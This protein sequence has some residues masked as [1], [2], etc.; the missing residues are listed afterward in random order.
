MSY[1]DWDELLGR[2]VELES[3]TWV[4]IRRA[5]E[6]SG[7]SRSTLRA[8]YRRGEVPSRLADGPHG[9]ERHVP[10][11]AVLERAA[12]AR[13]RGSRDGDDLADKVAQQAEEIAALRQRIDDL[14]R[15]AR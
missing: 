10:L 14:E 12:A 11:E 4:T 6:A 1:V 7:A 8:W 15:R 9:P 2:A 3:A 5:V 13:L